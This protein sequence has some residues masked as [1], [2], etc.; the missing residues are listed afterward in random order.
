[1]TEEP[2]SCRLRHYWFCS[3]NESQIEFA[4][5]STNITSVHVV[6]RRSSTL[7][8][9]MMNCKRH[10]AKVSMN[11]WLFLPIILTNSSNLL[12]VSSMEWRLVCPFCQIAWNAEVSTVYTRRRMIGCNILRIRLSPNTSKVNVAG[13]RRSNPYWGRVYLFDLRQSESIE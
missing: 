13:T 11:W 2:V 5:L 10:A 1:M 3:C 9:I 8:R 7:T 12:L 4:C 6:M